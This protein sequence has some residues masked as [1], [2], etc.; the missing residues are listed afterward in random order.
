MSKFLSKR[1][2][3]AVNKKINSVAEIVN[4][5]TEQGK[6]DLTVKLKGES[7]PIELCINYGRQ[8]NVICISEVKANREW[9]NALADIFKE[10]LSKINLKK[11]SKN[12]FARIGIKM[13]LHGKISKVGESKVNEKIN[14]VAEVV[15]LTIE[16]GKI[17]LTVRLKGESEPIDLCVNY[18]LQNDDLC[19][20]K[21]ESNK[22]WL[23]ALADIFMEQY[24]KIDLK[25]ISKNN[26][27]VKG[28]IKHFL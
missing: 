9:L 5:T 26:K 25:K 6:I 8:K 1:I 10:D 23:N 2:R 22:E 28:I 13:F 11:I 27:F 7:E 12:V 16:Q 21:V 14:R 4:L 18:V 19:I 24:P 15:N 17:N 20:S 3:S